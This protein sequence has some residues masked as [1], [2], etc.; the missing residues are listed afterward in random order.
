MS[1][2]M[3]TYLPMSWKDEYCRVW[4]YLVNYQPIHISTIYQSTHHFS[5][6]PSLHLII[7]FIRQSLLIHNY[8][9]HGFGDGELVNGQL[10]FIVLQH[11]DLVPGA[12]EQFLENIK[13]AINGPWSSVLKINIKLI[14]KAP[15]ISDGYLSHPMDRL[16]TRLRLNW[17]SVCY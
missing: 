16:L 11:L 10:T 1:F 14:L 5:I 13:S 12:L 2:T 17:K 9:M 6:Y 15:C 4:T 8:L 3:H 7:S